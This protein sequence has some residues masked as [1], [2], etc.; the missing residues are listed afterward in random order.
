MF[1]YNGVQFPLT[2][3]DDEE[4]VS[5]YY[6]KDDLEVNLEDY[7]SDCFKTCKLMDSNGHEVRL[8]MSVMSIEVIEYVAPST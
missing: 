7:N 4:E 1:N 2:L 3:I 8:I 5:V 6:D